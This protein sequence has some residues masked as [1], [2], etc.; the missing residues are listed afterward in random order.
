MKKALK[1]VSVLFIIA[2]ML[3]TGAFAAAPVEP[4]QPQSSKYIS[5]TSTVAG[6]LGG[7]RVRFSF[8]ITATDTMKDVGA[9]QVDIYEVGNPTPVKTC[10]HTSSAYDYIMG[11]DA[12]SHSAG[13]T[14]Y[15]ETG[16]QYY[17]NVTFYAG[18]YGVAG[19]IQVMGTAIVTAV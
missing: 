7:G 6:A 11:H 3:T 1:S 10:R 12:F 8:T 16:H 4:D 13:I 2:A 15:G 19:G 18:H 14:Y 17:A 9:S 5:E